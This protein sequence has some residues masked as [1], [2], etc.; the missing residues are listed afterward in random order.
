MGRSLRELSKECGK[1][2]I[3]FDSTLSNKQK[4]R[5]L[6]TGCYQLEL[7]NRSKVHREKRAVVGAAINRIALY[8]DYKF[9]NRKEFW[10]E[11]NKELRPLTNRVEIRAFI[12]KQMDRILADKNLMHYINLMTIEEQRKSMKPY[13]K[14]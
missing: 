1:C 9:E 11:I 5:A 6:C 14:D 3:V 7:D 12:S 10:R 4:G 8:K 2:G 13:D